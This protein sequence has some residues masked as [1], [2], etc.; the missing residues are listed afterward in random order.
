MVGPSVG[1]SVSQPVNQSIRW[2]ISS[3]TDRRSSSQSVGTLAN[4][5]RGGLLVIQPTI[6]LCQSVKSAV[7]QAGAV[8]PT[9]RLLIGQYVSLSAVRQTGSQPVN[10]STRLP[11]QHSVKQSIS[12]VCQ[13][14]A[15]QVSQVKSRSSVKINSIHSRP[16]VGE[17]NQSDSQ[18]DKPTDSQSR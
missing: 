8:R 17:G 1:Q 12:Q 7:K 11:N 15:R 3:Q 13:P 5:Q 4:Q 2:P 9:L 6:Q 16:S 14:A 10:Q 18:T